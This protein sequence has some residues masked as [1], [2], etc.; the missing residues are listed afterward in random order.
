MNQKTSIAALLLAFAWGTA[1]AQQAP[2]ANV[3]PQDKTQTAPRQ[4]GV[5][6]RADRLSK[7]MARDLHLNGYQAAKLRAIN[8]EKVAKM[9]AIERKNA[10]NPQLIDEQCNG[11][12][13]E[14][15]QE[16]REVLSNDQYSTYYGSRSTYYKYDKDYAAQSASILLVESVN[17]P[18]PSRANNA[19]IAP[20][21]E[22]PANRPAGSQGRSAR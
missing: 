3:Q 17:N 21:K 7:Q 4:S 5:Q 22:K 20:A 2:S 1:A 19:T 11:V 6:A 12:C 16:L 18:T 13:R 10:G 9:A 8:E 15:D 14:R